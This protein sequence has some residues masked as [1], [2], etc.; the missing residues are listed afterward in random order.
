LLG[1]SSLAVKFELV[2]PQAQQVPR[3]REQLFLDDRLGQEVVGAGD[4]AI[5]ARRRVG[6]RRHQDDRDERASRVGRAGGDT[7][8]D[9]RRQ[10]S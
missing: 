4:L 6:Q 1:L 2:R 9:R 5:G 10:A 8:R 3:A 7:A